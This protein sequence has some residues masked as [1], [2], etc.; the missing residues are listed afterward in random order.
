[1]A[2]RSTVNPAHYPSQTAPSQ[3]TK[4]RKKE[5]TANQ[6]LDP[7]AICRSQGVNLLALRF[8]LLT[9]LT[10]AGESEYLQHRYRVLPVYESKRQHPAQAFNAH[11][12][13]WDMNMDMDMD[14]AY[15]AVRMVADVIWV[16]GRNATAQSSIV[17]QLSESIYVDAFSDDC[18]GALGSSVDL[19]RQHILCSGL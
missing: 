13:L 6:G 17:S 10:V 15:S 19:W 8:L 2:G 16:R 1:M 3:R 5:N 9:L 12:R 14:P 18:L 11:T 4:E 7:S